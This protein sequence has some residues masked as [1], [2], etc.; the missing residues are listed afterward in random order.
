MAA[1][2]GGRRQ[3]GAVNG[4][5]FVVGGEK[6]RLV[7]LGRARGARALVGLG[8]ASWARALVGLGGARGASRAR[9]R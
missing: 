9:G 1:G 4:S 2:A 6:R 8:G 7:G 5:R 3:A